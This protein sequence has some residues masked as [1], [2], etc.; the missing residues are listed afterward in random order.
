ML[1]IDYDLTKQAFIDLGVSDFDHMYSQAAANELFQQL[2]KGTITPEEFREVLKEQTGLSLSEEEIHTAW[3]ALLLDFRKSSLEY[4]KMLKQ[5]ANLILLSNTN[6]IHRDAFIKIYD[7]LKA[8]SPFN[9]Y[10]HHCFYSF[11]IGYR[12]PDAACFKWVLNETGIRADET[13]FI[14]DSPQNIEAAQAL[15][16][17]SIL[18][19][20]GQ[21]IE[22]L[23]LEEL[24]SGAG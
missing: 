2:E 5:R 13:V 9:E 18:L 1:D 22:E 10:F 7:E 14:D 17:H 4:L 20:E 11:D 23:G 19:G 6:A 16:I 21:L 3:N 12:K 8:G 15:G 24:V